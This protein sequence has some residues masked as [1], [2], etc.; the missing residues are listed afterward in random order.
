L[1]FFKLFSLKNRNFDERIKIESYDQV[2]E[3]IICLN[4]TS[5]LLKIHPKSIPKIFDVQTSDDF[6]YS[7]VT[8]EEE[9]EKR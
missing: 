1:K 2:Q 9:S 3:L 6:N 4:Y 5:E 7:N 8:D